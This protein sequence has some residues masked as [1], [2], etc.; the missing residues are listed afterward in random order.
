MAEAVGSRGWRLT[1][2]GI[3]PNKNRTLRNGSNNVIG[4]P[5]RK[6]RYVGRVWLKIQDLGYAGLHVLEAQPAHWSKDAL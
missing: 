4:N 2:R 3:G 5:A 1:W 6:C